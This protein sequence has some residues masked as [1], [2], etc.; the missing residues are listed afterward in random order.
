MADMTPEPCV[1]NCSDRFTYDEQHR[2]A[3]TNW[4]LNKLVLPCQ[5]KI[6]FD[7]SLTWFT[8]KEWWCG[9]RLSHLSILVSPLSRFFKNGED[10]N[11]DTEA[12]RK[13]NKKWCFNELMLYFNQQ[14]QAAKWL[15]KTK[16]QKVQIRMN[17]RNTGETLGENRTGKQTRKHTRLQY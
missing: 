12:D 9:A 13:T 17:T 7:L 15:E 16:Q 14:R 3:H 6:Q 11:A 8:L 1:C 2:A 4:C 5:V 10:P